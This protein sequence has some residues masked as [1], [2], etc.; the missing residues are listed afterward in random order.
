[1]NIRFRYTYFALFVCLVSAFQYSALDN[2]AKPSDLSA[3]IDR[4]ISQLNSTNTEDAQAAKDWLMNS[5][6]AVLPLIEAAATRATG[7]AA[8]R[9]EALLKELKPLAKNAFRPLS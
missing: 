4:R 1:M 6:P 2:I 5:E 8:L 3:E 7:D 9:M